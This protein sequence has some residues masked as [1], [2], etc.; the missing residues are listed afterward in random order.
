VAAHDHHELARVVVEQEA[1]ALHRAEPAA[2]LA[3]PVVELAARL[4]RA[5]E[6]AQQLDDHVERVRA[7]RE[8][9]R[10]PFF[11]RFSGDRVTTWLRTGHR[12]VLARTT[13]A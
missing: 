7:L 4:S 3:Q 1:C 12:P 10:H 13:R 2:R 5:V 9:L 8:G 6:R 11:Y